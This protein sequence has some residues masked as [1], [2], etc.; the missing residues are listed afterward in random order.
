MSRKLPAVIMV[1]MVAV[2][3]CPQGKAF[4]QTPVW[5]NFS[6]MYDINGVTVSGGKVWAATSG[7]VFSYSPASRTFSQFTTTEGL[8]NI[9]ATSIISDSGDILVGEGDG[10]IDELNSSGVQYRSQTDIAK[11]PQLNKQVIDLTLVG[12]TLFACTPFGVVLISKSSFVVL[13]SYLHFFPGHATSQANSL[14][15]FGGN[16]YVAGQ[17]G[18]SF[19]SASAPN[20]SAPD[21]WHVS[22][23]TGVDSATALSVLNDSL[24]I[25]G[26]KEGIFYSTDGT[27]FQVIPSSTSIGIVSAFAPAKNS[28]IVI[29]QDGLFKLSSDETL[30]SFVADQFGLQCAAQYSDTMVIAGSSRGLVTVGSSVQTVLPPGPGTNVI[31][32][33]SIDNSGNLWCATSRN[34]DQSNAGV[35]FMEF[36]GT[37]WRNFSKGQNPIL[38]TDDYFQ[39]SAVCGGVVVAGA[40]GG[41]KPGGTPNG[42]MAL[43][44]GDT[45]VKTFNTTNSQLVGIPVDEYYVV[46]GNAACDANGNIW[47]TNMDAYN[48]NVLAVY[49]P[50]DSSW[51]T[52]H[53]GYSSPSGFVPITVDGYGGV[54]AGD[55]YG[56]AQ[57]YVQ[58]TYHGV[59]YYNANGTLDNTSDDVSRLVTTDYGLLSN[60]VNSVVTDNENQVWIGTTLGL[61]V[62]YDASSPTSLASIYSMLD[63]YVW[64]IDY[65]A[66][67]EKWVSTT[68][69]VYV[70]SKDGNTRIVQ[71]NS[72]NSYLPSDNVI[73]V[74]CDRVHGIVYFATDYGVTQLKMGIVQPLTNFS[75]IKVYP[76][77][78]VFPLKGQVQIVGLVAGCEIKIFSVA[79]KLVRNFEAQG[80]NIAYWDGNDDSGRALPS[81]VYIIIAYSSDGSQSAVT[82]VAV[83]R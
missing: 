41:P 65:D 73:S 79:G 11:S 82:K 2:F 3:V 20:L 24:L 19:A 74:A 61:N 44:S 59:F 1:T 64:A 83:V 60:Q 71:Y 75:K 5:K 53:N 13:D 16:V 22:S 81:G 30:T 63:Q 78:V 45:I 80:G 48:G 29:S 76:N 26:T 14:A 42:G 70:L 34:S 27:T 4:S 40:W 54:W 8:S 69:G 33:L 25:V 39:I 46:V 62:A 7:G 38:P 9:Q 67:D 49:S 66:L 17:Y 18:L 50:K 6:C 72:T 21:P 55:E 58:G 68:T 43:L 37:A 28:L 31:N 36:D 15:F 56:E 51:H 10:T 35:A 32:H 12:D 52:F 23:M 47:M 77:P 57:G